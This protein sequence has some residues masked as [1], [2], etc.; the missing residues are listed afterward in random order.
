MRRPHRS[1][2]RSMWTVLAVVIPAILIGAF[3]ARQ[4]EPESKAAVQVAPPAGEAQ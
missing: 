1:A 3:L 4:T 2:H